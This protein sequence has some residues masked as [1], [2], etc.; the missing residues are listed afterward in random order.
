[1]TSKKKADDAEVK[2]KKKRRVTQPLTEK[3]LEQLKAY[4]KEA[5]IN[6]RPS[7]YTEEL[8]DYICSLVATHDIGIEQLVKIHDGLPE[9]TTIYRWRY[10]K[11]GFRAKYALAKAAQADLLA[12]Q[13]L[14]ISD[15]SGSDIKVDEFGNKSMD[16]E[17]VQRSRLRIDTRKWLAGK[18]MPKQ[19][20]DARQIE[21]LN[22]ENDI[23]KKE[24]IELRA[25]LDAK[26][27][28]DY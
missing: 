16:G 18:L 13:I 4:K 26:H 12:E 1:M 23:L 14:C 2:P 21:S 25:K 24:L 27:E 6:G 10:E 22:V 28:K 8:A 9:K 15:D 3:D 11:P 19:Y 20:G 5:G 7:I 17:F